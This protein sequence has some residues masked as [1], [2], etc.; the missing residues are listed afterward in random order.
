MDMIMVD[1]S[2]V[3]CKVGDY[4]VILGKQGNHNIDANLL[5]TFNSTIPYEILT[6]FNLI[7]NST[8]VN[9]TE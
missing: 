1:A 4:A 7:K 2:N 6:N 8:T 3:K 5:A 9:G